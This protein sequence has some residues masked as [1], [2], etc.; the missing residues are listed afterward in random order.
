MSFL[1][2]CS[3]VPFLKQSISCCFLSNSAT[4]S[5]ATYRPFLLILHTL[6][7]RNA[8][9]NFKRGKRDSDA[10]ATT[11][12]YPV[13]CS[14]VQQTTAFFLPSG[15]LDFSPN[16][17]NTRIELLHLPSLD[18]RG[19]KDEFKRFQSLRVEV[20]KVSFCVIKALIFLAIILV[21]L[22]RKATLSTF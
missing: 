2:Q 3:F 8:L 4:L 9:S 6:L 18:V 5:R 20:V 22:I 14:T 12:V 7:P 11:V 16:G 17:L 10:T 13:A 21:L 15:S 1:L 19:A